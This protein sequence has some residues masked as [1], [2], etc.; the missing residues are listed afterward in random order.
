MRS[1]GLL[2]ELL[3]LSLGFSSFLNINRGSGNETVMRIL[4]REFSSLKVREWRIILPFQV[5]LRSSVVLSSGRSSTLQGCWSSIYLLQ[6]RIGVS[7]AVIQSYSLCPTQAVSF[8]LVLRSRKVFSAL[9]FRFEAK[10]ISSKF[11]VLL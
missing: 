7:T 1:V 9:Q 3:S 11:I 6:R 10:R 2:H 4:I 8:L 5:L